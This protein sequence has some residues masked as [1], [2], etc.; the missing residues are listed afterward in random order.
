MY[1]FIFRGLS[2]LI[3]S[4]ATSGSR[5][6][7]TY[8]F[9]IRNVQSWAVQICTWSWIY[10]LK[11]QLSEPLHSLTHTPPHQ[12]GPFFFFPPASRLNINSINVLCGKPALTI[13][14]Y[15]KNP[16]VT[17]ARWKGPTFAL[18]KKL[19]WWFWLCLSGVH[20]N[21]I[22]M[23]VALAKQAHKYSNSPANASKNA[24]APHSRNSASPR[25]RERSYFQRMFSTQT[26]TTCSPPK[27]VVRS[28]CEKI[29]AVPTV[30]H[31]PGWFA[32]YGANQHTHLAS[33]H[34][35]KYR[36]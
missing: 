15:K 34:M 22:I 7:L 29:R 35:V 16:Y 25:Q 13:Q 5:D 17:T 31:V 9:R 23:K 10:S 1:I 21:L 28:D 19:C 8:V 27:K 6:A 36:K 11:T 2:G 30:T 18:S 26:N 24:T 20:I 12:Q 3:V 33:F 32:E 14:K 4:S